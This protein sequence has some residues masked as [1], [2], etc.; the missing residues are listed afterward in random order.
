MNCDML[1]LSL[2]IA[3]DKLLRECNVCALLSFGVLQTS[4]VR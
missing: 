4:S 3:Y 1:S 2:E